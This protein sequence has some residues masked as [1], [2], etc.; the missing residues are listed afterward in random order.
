MFKVKNQLG[1]FSKFLKTE[2]DSVR[3]DIQYL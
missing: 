2:L 1:N 3:E